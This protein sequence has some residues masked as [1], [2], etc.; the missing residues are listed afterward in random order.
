MQTAGHFPPTLPSFFLPAT[1]PH[2]K[3]LWKVTL[4]DLRVW[5]LSWLL[6]GQLDISPPLHLHFSFLLLN[7]IPRWL[8]S[9]FSISVG[10]SE[11]SWTSP[12][13][14][15]HFPSCHYHPKMLH[16]HF[17]LFQPPLPPSILTPKLLLNHY[18]MHAFLS[19]QPQFYL[20]FW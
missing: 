2:P 20:Q 15:L 16:G 10:F 8:T 12:Q 13:I 18:V 5:Y 7:H 3:I 6:W 11:N 17:P 4:P 14:Y 9:E 19:R 1:E